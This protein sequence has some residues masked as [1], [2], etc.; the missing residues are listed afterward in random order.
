M[1]CYVNKTTEG[2]HTNMKYLEYMEENQYENMSWCKPYKDKSEKYTLVVHE[3][4]PL[5]IMSPTTEAHR[6]DGS[7]NDEMMEQFARAV[8]PDYNEYSGWSDVQIALDAMHEVGCASCPWKEDCDAMGE[9]MDKLD[10]R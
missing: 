8:N 5:S 3:G 7:L 9:E 2:R 6:Y 4:E 1:Y 10:Y